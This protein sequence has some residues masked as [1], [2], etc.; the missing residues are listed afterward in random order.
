MLDACVIGCSWIGAYY[1]RQWLSGVFGY[2]LNPIASYL[3]VLPVVVLLCLVANAYFGLYRRKRGASGLEDAQAVIKSALLG[4]FIIGTMAFLVKELSIA[5]SVVI[6]NFLL[7]LL[8]YTVVRMAVRK[9]ETS[10]MRKGLG[11]VRC[12]IVGTSSTGIRALQKISDH[13]EIGYEVVGFVET[14]HENVG[15]KISNVPVLGTLDDLGRI[16]DEYELDE[17]IIAVP[18]M[19]Q[20]MILHLISS[21]SDRDVSFRVISNVFEVLSRELKV[22]VLEEFPIFNLG[23]GHVSRFYT[24]SKRIMDF[25]SALVLLVVTLPL[26]IVI[27]VAIKL[28]SPGP[29]FFVHER[30]GYKGRRFRMYKFRTMRTD[31]SPYEEAPRTSRDPRVTRVGQFL[32]RTSLD[33]L[34]QL[35]NVLKGEMSLVGPR[36][37]MPFIVEKYNEWQKLRLNAVPGITGL[38]QILGRK[39]IPLHENLEYDF[40]YIKNRSLLFDLVILLKTIPAV[41]KRKGA[42]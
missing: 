42:F 9:A 29:V 16:I 17:V 1:L 21:V 14:D 37:E 13:P 18:S 8:G 4:L 15:E 11:R 27:A 38:W 2:P 31:T 25:V 33:E 24:V 39:D 20:D 12:I 32:R 28:D 35:I 7:N 41:L 5:R 19:P 10:L 34:P 40:Y 22:D 30:V 6:F 3:H 26:W 36:P 23:T